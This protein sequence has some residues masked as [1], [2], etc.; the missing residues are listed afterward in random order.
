MISTTLQYI[1]IR[2]TSVVI[3]RGKSISHSILYRLRKTIY[4]QI[5]RCQTRNCMYDFSMRNVNIVFEENR[6]IMKKKTRQYIG[7]TILTWFMI[8]LQSEFQCLLSTHQRTMDKAYTREMIWH[9]LYY[10]LIRVYVTHRRAILTISVSLLR[11]PF[12]RLH[13]IVLNETVARRSSE[14]IRSIR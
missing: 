5:E 6:F 12:D 7:C 9:F 1:V 13:A 4:I 10:W 14:F 3:T 2:S 8:F 11:K